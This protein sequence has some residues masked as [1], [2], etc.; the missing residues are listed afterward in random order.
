ME[1]RSFG[2]SVGRF[3][4][5]K[6]GVR[7]PS[8]LFRDVAG[9]ARQGIKNDKGF[10][11]ILVDRDGLS[12]ISAHFLFVSDGD[13]AQMNDGGQKGG[14][15]DGANG[16]SKIFHRKNFSGDKKASMIRGFWK[17]KDDNQ[18]AVFKIPVSLSAA[19]TGSILSTAA[20]SVTNRSKACS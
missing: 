11:E 17:L 18:A 13:F 5:V 19:D 20:N 7:H 10:S 8:D 15:E 3:D 1:F 4:F 14:K 16:I 2:Q 9:M 12:G 6:I